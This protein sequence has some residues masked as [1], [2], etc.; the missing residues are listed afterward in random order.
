MDFIIIN[1]ILLIYKIIYYST[2][3]IISYKSGLDSN[4][5]LGL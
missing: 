5:D 3:Y 4:I 2:I 1:S